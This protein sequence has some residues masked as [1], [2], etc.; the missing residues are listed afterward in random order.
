MKIQNTANAKA[1]KIKMAVY[2]PSGAG[3]T[4][5]AATCPRP[6]LISLESGTLSLAG[7]DI[8]YI[9][10][11][12]NNTG[13]VIPKERRAQRIVEIYQYLNTKDAKEKY[14][15][16]IL[17]SLTEIGQCMVDYAAN[18]YPDPK[19]SFPKWGLYNTKMI[20]MI[21]GFRDLPDYHVLFTA[22]S[23]TEKDENGMRYANIDLQGSIADKFPGFFDIVM[24]LNVAKDGVRTLI[25]GRTPNII[26]KDR[27]GKL[28]HVEPPDLGVIINKIL[29]EEKNHVV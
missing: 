11:S 23:V 12:R 5:L 26:A 10:A 19:D 20:G 21:K 28:D 16:V 2:G 8:P 3:K 15:T 7:K 24:Y 4:C 1:S 18:E 13:E 17:D 14:E 6:L 27:S 9:D 25:T 22:L 29:K